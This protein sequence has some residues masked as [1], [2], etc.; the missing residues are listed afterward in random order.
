M[1]QFLQDRFK[2]FGYALKGIY[3]FFS[4]QVHPKIHLLAIVVISILGYFLGL[5]ATE[6]CLIIICMAIVLLAE[7]INSALED[8]VDLV[9]PDYHPIAGR[10]KDIAAGAVLL[11][12]I[13]CGIVW[14]II[15]LPKIFLLFAT[16]HK[17]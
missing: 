10:V 5:T 11:A 9:S 4:T 17:P 7:G 13:L 16:E 2:S 8:L 12:V 1:W 6:W 15:F 3:L 14:G